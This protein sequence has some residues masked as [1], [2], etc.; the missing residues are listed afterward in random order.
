MI[1]ASGF[2]FGTT[3][4][5][6]NSF[7][8]ASLVVKAPEVGFGYGTVV[9]TN[10]WWGTTDAGEIGALI[11]DIF[12]DATLSEVVFVP[13]LNAPPSNIGSAIP[14]DITLPRL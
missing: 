13:F 9:A 3:S 4:L 2:Y 1:F 11:Q 8:G 10:N 14:S 7:E 5:E 6:Q 12:D